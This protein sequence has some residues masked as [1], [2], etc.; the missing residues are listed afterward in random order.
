MDTAR[1]CLGVAAMVFFGACALIGW[2]LMVILP[3]LSG[4]RPIANLGILTLATAV[5][6]VVWRLAGGPG[7][8]LSP[9]NGADQAAKKPSTPKGASEAAREH[10]LPD[11]WSRVLALRGLTAEAVRETVDRAYAPRGSRV[12]PKR[13]RLFRAFELTSVRNTR[14]VVLGQD[15]YWKRGQ[16]DGLAFSVKPGV[17]FPYS[18]RRIFSN[19]ESDPAFQF[20]RP[21]EGS[22]K[23]WAR[24]GVLLLNSA[25]TVE[26]GAPGSHRNHW[27]QFT[28]LVLEA[29]NDKDD[30]V[31]FLLWGDDANALADAVPINQS[32]HLVIRSTHPRR[33]EASQYPRFADTRPFSQ[34]N[35]FLRS[36]GR[37]SVDWTL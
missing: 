9:E 24:S 23:R 10:E 8:G 19:L 28:R 4:Q 21:T 29:V 36:R 27:A 1:G 33:E 30:P 32:R 15:P 6:L 34:A 14:V 5:S 31:V 20:H 11:D 37:P 17:E 26:E 25:L 22:L 13:R 7:W 16:A 18:L 2:V 12:L 3:V 35:D